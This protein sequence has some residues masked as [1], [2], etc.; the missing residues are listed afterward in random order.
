[1]VLT[2]AQTDKAY[3]DLVRSIQTRGPSTFTKPEYKGIITKTDAAVGRL[4]TSLRTSFTTREGTLT[5]TDIENLILA[6]IQ[7]RLN[8]PAAESVSRG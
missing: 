4:I 3:G 7:T 5:D 2:D 6:V 1:M 8:P